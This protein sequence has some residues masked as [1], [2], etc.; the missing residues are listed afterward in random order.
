LVSQAGLQNGQ[1]YALSS[2]DTYLNRV[3]RKGTLRRAD[4][5]KWFVVC[6]G[7]GVALFV[8]M[9]IMVFNSSLTKSLV[10]VSVATAFIAALIA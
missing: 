3:I 8:S 5:P 4:F 1:G 10:T 9:V 6:I 7:G 2:L